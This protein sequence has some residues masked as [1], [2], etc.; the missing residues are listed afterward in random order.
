[1]N[2]A[3]ATGAGS[4]KGKHIAK[5]FYSPSS[6]RKSFSARELM[7]AKPNLQFSK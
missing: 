3:L 1:V 7:N 5:M 2:I 6:S 4:L